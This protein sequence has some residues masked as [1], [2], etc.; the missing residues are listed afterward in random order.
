MYADVQ[1]PG[2]TLE[3]LPNAL[4]VD[5]NSQINFGS[6]TGGG[7]INVDSSN[8]ITLNIGSNNSNTVY[9]GVLSGFA[10]LTKVGSG[11]LNAG[12]HQYLFRVDRDQQRHLDRDGQWRPGIGPRPGRRR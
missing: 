7:N 6:L 12:E 8:L 11:T 4:L 9:S 5:A 3:R 10:G 1:V 2:G